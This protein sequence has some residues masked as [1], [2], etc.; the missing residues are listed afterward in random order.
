MATAGF[1]GQSGGHERQYESAEQCDKGDAK[2]DHVE[3]SFFSGRDR[4]RPT[5]LL[6][7]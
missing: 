1:P 7:P 4:L 2:P 5:L 6:S 3:T